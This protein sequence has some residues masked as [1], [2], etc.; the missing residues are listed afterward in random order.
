MRRVLILSTVLVAAC[1]ASGAAM[2]Q[3]QGQT[4]TTADGLR[5]LSWPGKVKT[6]QAAA[7]RAAAPSPTPVG[8]SL[9]LPRITAPPPAASSPRRGLTPASDWTSPPVHA[10]TAAAPSP[11]PSALPEQVLVEAQGQAEAASAA[12][13]FDP[14]APRRDAPIFRLQAQTAPRLNPSETSDSSPAPAPQTADQPP[15]V[16]AALSSAPVLG[17]RFYSVH[18][19]AGRKPDPIAPAQPVYLDALPVEMT[20]TPSSADLARPD[21]PPALLRNSDGTV[22]AAP[23]TQEDALP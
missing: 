3:A 23:Q 2:A 19:Q 10:Q 13:V 11:A 9:P 15:I 20:Q 21:G 12:A 5:Y 14:M 7:P 18:R 6:G 8:R 16:Q 22:R 1:A 17:A 4:Q